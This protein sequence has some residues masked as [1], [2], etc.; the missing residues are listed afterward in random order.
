V[1][2]PVRSREKDRANVAGLGRDTT[3]EHLRVQGQN[4]RE[5]DA[6]TKGRGSGAPDAAL[7]VGK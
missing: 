1:H 2:I 3:I 6:P 5:N 4:V 7:P